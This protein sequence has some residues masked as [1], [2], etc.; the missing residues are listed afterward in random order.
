MRTAT[1]DKSYGA[2]HRY[3]GYF[4]LHVRNVRALVS[5]GSD[6]LNECSSHGRRIRLEIGKSQVVVSLLLLLSSEL[7]EGQTHSSLEVRMDGG[8]EWRSYVVISLLLLF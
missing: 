4:T 8:H 6:N 3:T 2:V 7:H 1:E 5:F